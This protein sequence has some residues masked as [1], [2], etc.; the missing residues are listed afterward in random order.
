MSESE[1]RTIREIL[2]TARVIAVVGLSRH[3]W[4]PSNRVSGYMQA[5]GYR[6]IPVNPN[7]RE[8]LGEKAYATLEDV[9]EKIDLVNVFRRSEF[10][11]PVVESA[12]RVGAKAVWMQ[13]EV[14]HEEAAER[15]Q[16][17]GLRVVM[18]RC[19]MQEHLQWKRERAS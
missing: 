7:E 19:I 10:V 18:D 11:P 14:V 12:I 2:E 3:A 9:P 15:A 13:E 8:V 1:E 16:L 6:I 5:A 4:R 17:A